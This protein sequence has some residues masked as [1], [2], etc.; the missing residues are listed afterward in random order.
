MFA[1]RCSITKGKK[2]TSVINIRQSTRQPQVHLRSVLPPAHRLLC[3]PS[4]PR[5]APDLDPDGS[6]EVLIYAAAA[7]C[8]V[9][10][11]DENT[12]RCAFAMSMFP[13]PFNSP[14]LTRGGKRSAQSEVLFIARTFLSLLDL[15]CSAA[16]SLPDCSPLP[17]SIPLISDRKV[18]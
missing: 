6:S 2:L 13:L 9:H 14:T 18:L 10:Y 12:Q 15:V 16:I 8:V 4:T 7:L 17:Y 11:L 3:P 5:R 1:R